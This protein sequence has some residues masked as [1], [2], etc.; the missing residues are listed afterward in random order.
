MNLCPSCIPHTHGHNSRTASSANGAITLLL[1][2]GEN[3]RPQRC[4]GVAAAGCCGGKRPQHRRWD[5]N[6]YV[7]RRTGND[8][9]RIIVVVVDNEQ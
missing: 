8:G 2:A 3:D 5:Y 9:W 4:Y 7:D 1:R 6:L